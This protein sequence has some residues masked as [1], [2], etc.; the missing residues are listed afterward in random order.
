MSKFRG[1][2]IELRNALFSVFLCLILGSCAYYAQYDVTE[3]PNYDY[4]IGKNFS[5]SIYKGR[6][7]YKVVRETA[8]VE[9]LEERRSNGCILVFGVRKTDDIIEYWRVD[10]GAGTCLTRKKPLNR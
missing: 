10:S 8:T 4:L 5:A 6:Q 3:P 9:E 1:G 2:A 7:V